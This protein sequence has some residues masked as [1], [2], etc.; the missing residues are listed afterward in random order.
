MSEVLA[1]TLSCW[2][3][4]RQLGC[5]RLRKGCLHLQRGSAFAAQLQKSHSPFAVQHCQILP[6]TG[7]WGHAQEWVRT[8]GQNELIC[9]HNTPCLILRRTHHSMLYLPLQ[10][11]HHSTCCH[12][13]L[14]VHHNTCCRLWL[15]CH[16][17]P[18]QTVRSCPDNPSSR[19]PMPSKAAQACRHTHSM[20]ARSVDQHSLRTETK[21]NRPCCRARCPNNVSSV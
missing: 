19:R 20:H 3:A 16:C 6:Q 13:W 4:L 18:C 8:H 11:C 15:T 21:T 17:M 7:D 12:P 5:L 1:Y 9:R 10:T 2:V 14:T